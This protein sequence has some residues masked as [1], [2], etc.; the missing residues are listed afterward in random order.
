MES[1]F[2]RFFLRFS[3]ATRQSSSKWVCDQLRSHWDTII[4]ADKSHFNSKPRKSNEKSLYLMISVEDTCCL[5][6]HPVHSHENVWQM[7]MRLSFEFTALVPLSCS[8]TR[9][10]VAPDFFS[11]LLSTLNWHEQQRRNKEKA[12]KNRK[13]ISPQWK[14]ISFPF[15][16]LRRRPANTRT[17][18]LPT[19]AFTGKLALRRTTAIMKCSNGSRASPQVFVIKLDSCSPNVKFIHQFNCVVALN[20]LEVE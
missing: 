15:L 8:K 14:F 17:I 2:Y 12:R 16:S 18:E 6:L 4:Q 10:S 1:K 7:W 13:A 3:F 20:W 19:T 5:H 9:L 11:L